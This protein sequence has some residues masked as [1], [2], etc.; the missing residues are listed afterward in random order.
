MASLPTA[1]FDHAAAALHGKLYVMGGVDSHYNVL[2]SVEVYDPAQPKAAWAAT[3]PMG[4]ARAAF[5]AATLGNTV[6]ATGGNDDSGDTMTSAEISCVHSIIGKVFALERAVLVAN[7]AI[8]RDL[9][10]I[11][12]NLHFH[13]AC[14]GV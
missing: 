6:Y 14:N 11:E 5:A 8:L 13:V 10:R 9:R 3:P 12:L 1:R 7:E 2:N 4:T